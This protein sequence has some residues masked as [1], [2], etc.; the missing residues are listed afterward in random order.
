MSKTN[1]ILLIVSAIALVWGVRLELIELFA[2]QTPYWDDWGMGG[3]VTRA[4]VDG[5]EW[6]SLLRNA[7][8]HRM[9]FNRIWSIALFSMNQEQWDPIVWMLSNAL[10]WAISGAVL[11]AIIQKNAPTNNR[12]VLIIFVLVLWVIPF[13]IVN[14][15]WG[16]QTHTYT[17]ILFSVLGC[18]WV[19]DR[20]FSLKWFLGLLSLAAATL[21][22]AGGTFAS[23]AVIG[24]SLIAFIAAR[25]STDRKAHL[26]TAV[27][28]I[29]PAIIG[30]SLIASL[31][32][33][34]SQGLVIG[35]AAIT[36]LKTMS[37]PDVRHIY[38]APIFAI[39]IVI[40]LV[41]IFRHGITPSRFAQFALSLFAFIVVVA[42]AVAYARGA[43]G[44]G[45]ARRYFE[46]LSLIPL[47]SF[48]ALCVIS[49]GVYRIN[50]K[51]ATAIF[52]LFIT[53]FIAGMPMQFKA[54]HFTLTERAT[55]KAAQT[56]ITSRYLN[57]GNPDEL[58]G[59]PHRHAP[60]PNIKMFQGI[61]D[62][63]ASADSLPSSLQPQPDLQWH[64]EVG[65][66]ERSNSAFIR[67]GA[68]VE[69]DGVIGSDHLGEPAYGSYNPELGGELATGTFVSAT[70][71]I[72]R[73]F[74]EISYMGNFN[75]NNMSISL[76][77]VETGKLYQ[78][79]PTSYQSRYT[80]W[81]HPKVWS[82]TYFKIPRGYY[83]IIATDNDPESW[84][85][86]G[87]P[88]SVGRLSYYAQ[89]LNGYSHWIWKVALFMLL[90]SLRDSLRNLFLSRQPTA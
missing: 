59:H 31:N 35:D 42:L 50:A 73:S 78:I 77:N 44:I 51:A 37:W 8:E 27:G 68:N 11:I 79:K 13:S 28:A 52:A 39:P 16:I 29:L 87:S 70:V 72:T 60:F 24:V 48:M 30:L 54:I 5:F 63:L 26:I 66:S 9:T 22:L 64:P 57:T 74:A 20:V 40:L 7:N 12:V 47:S 89:Q 82:T 62:E 34:E 38:H 71:R 32:R 88:R 81:P 53:A 21:T 23:V 67:N 84:F 83:N 80:S 49:N 33:P 65:E 85:A 6:S 1:Y 90:F 4:H 15:L 3:Y 14:V 36:F 56:H 43:G 61:L 18:W 69:I 86:F 17:M 45:P 46:Y 58:Y 19:T 55:L 41:Q 25:K 75:G 10:I 76:E 2:V